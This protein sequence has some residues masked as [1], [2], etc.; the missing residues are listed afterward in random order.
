NEI[1]GLGIEAEGASLGEAVSYDLSLASGSDTVARVTVI[2]PDGEER[3]WYADNGRIADG[4]AS[5][6][7]TPA[8]NDPT[9]TW[10]IRA[11]DIITGETAEAEVEVRG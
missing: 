5:G 9:G 4:V 2:G 3:P 11:L 10:T 7:F 6:S 8:L 1:A